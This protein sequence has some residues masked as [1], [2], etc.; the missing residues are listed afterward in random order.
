MPVAVTS[1]AVEDKVVETLATF[2]PEPE[3]ITRD[4]TFES[5]DVDSLDLVELAQVV[6]EEF[7]V[8]LKGDDMK[9]IR[10]VGDAIELVVTRAG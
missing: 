8:S 4:A 7:G 1:E 3:Q 2:G 6:D 10:T 9:G 5:L